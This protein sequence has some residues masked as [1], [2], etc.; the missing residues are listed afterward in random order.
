MV[1]I[2]GLLGESGGLVDGVLTTIG[3]I[4]GS[5]GGV[6]VDGDHVEMGIVTLVDEDLVALSNNDDIP[7][8]YGTG[9]AHEHGENAV[10]GEDGS[11]V[12]LSEL[13]DDGI[14]GGGDV[15]SSTVD[16]CELLLGALDG[17]LVEG[18]VIGVEEAV[19]V[20]I[21]TIVS[22]Q[23]QLSQTV[24]INLL[25]K[26]PLR[27][28]VDTSIAVASRL[29]PILPAKAAATPGTGVL[30]TTTV[31]TTT[32]VAPSTTGTG[33]LELS[34]STPGIASSTTLAT[35]TTGEDGTSAVSGLGRVASVADDGEGG[36]VLGGRGVE[37]EGVAGTVD[38]LI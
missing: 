9:R 8:V 6:L 23:V 16:G 20:D 10:G 31:V 4:E 36:L 19:V 38:L 7:G 1:D 3:S 18:A 32:A 28:D 25:E 34:T 26:L 11:L 27:L 33:P 37:G 13:L 12:L 21:L 15:V 17:V 22:L 30:A 24:E 29:V 14:R 2:G 35:A 5:I